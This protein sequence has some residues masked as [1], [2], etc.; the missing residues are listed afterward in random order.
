MTFNDLYKKI[1]YEDN[2][3]GSGVVFGSGSVGTNA[4]LQGDIYNTG[5]SR[6]AKIIGGSVIKRGGLVNKRKKRKKS[7]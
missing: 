7:R 5:D 3:S 4:S 2:M 6:V 1:L